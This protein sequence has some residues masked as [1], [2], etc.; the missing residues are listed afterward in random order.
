MGKEYKDILLE[1]I[2]TEK[3][4]AL[5]QHGKYS[6]IV[7]ID[8]TKF[9]IKEAF[10]KV[11][12]DLKVVDVNTVKVRGHWRR[13]RT[14]IKGPRDKKKAIITVDGGKIDYFPETA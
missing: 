3:S 13:T 9:Q 1:P 5:S 2:I 14:G 4:T 6:F 11:F 7:S 8:A 10:K 12:P